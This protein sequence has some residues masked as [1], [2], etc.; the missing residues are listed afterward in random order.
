MTAGLYPMQCSLVKVEPC[1][2]RLVSLVARPQSRFA[3]CVLMLF[4]GRLHYV[5]HLNG[6]SL[7]WLLLSVIRALQAAV[8]LRWCLPGRKALSLVTFFIVL[9]VILHASHFFTDSK[10]RDIVYLPC[11]L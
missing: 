5:M 8:G 7:Q 4:E 6:I 9:K 10:S 11:I 3:V 1:L 2:S